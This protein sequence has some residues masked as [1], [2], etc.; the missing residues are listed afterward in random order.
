M[1]GSLFEEI[2]TGIKGLLSWI[3]ERFN[4]PMDI[5]INKESN[6]YSGVIIPPGVTTAVIP[7][8]STAKNILGDLWFM[9]TS[10]V[11]LFLGR[12]VK[13]PFIQ[14]ILKSKTSKKV[15]S[16]IDKLEKRLDKFI[17]CFCF[18]YLYG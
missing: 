16:I 7:K 14:K 10:V 17:F 4:G 8:P 13:I 15:S 5:R 18:L 3:N 9:G 12:I 1:L 6:G 11:G 2:G